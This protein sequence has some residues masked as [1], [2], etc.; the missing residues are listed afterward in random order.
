L[1]VVGIY[2]V[3]VYLNVLLCDVRSLDGIVSR[4][5]MGQPRNCGSVPGRDKRFFFFPVKFPHP[6]SILVSGCRGHLLRGQ[7]SRDMKLTDHLHIVQR[8]R[9]IGAIPPLWPAQGQ[10]Y[11]YSVVYRNFQADVPEMKVG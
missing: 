9:M 3:D 6:S 7:N 1:Y 11:L 4:K 2:C 8:L 5:W 10:H